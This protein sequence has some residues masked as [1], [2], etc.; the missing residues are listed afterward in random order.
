MRFNADW[1]KPFLVFD[2]FPAMTALQAL[3]EPA[4]RIMFNKQVTA[5]AR[6]TF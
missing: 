6:A 5:T 2:Q 3:Y 1:Y 4:V